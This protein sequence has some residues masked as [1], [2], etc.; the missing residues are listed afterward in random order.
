[1]GLGYLFARFKL[2]EQAKFLPQSNFIVLMLALP[3]FNLYLMGIKLDLQNPEPW[4][5]VAKSVTWIGIRA[6][7]MCLAVLRVLPAGSPATPGFPLPTP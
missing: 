5:K 2:L 4:K 7:I 1:M 3:A 6:T